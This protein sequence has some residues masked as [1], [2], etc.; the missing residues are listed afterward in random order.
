MLGRVHS[1]NVCLYDLRCNVVSYQGPTVKIFIGR[2]H[3]NG[4]SK[5]KSQYIDRASCERQ[6]TAKESERIIRSVWED[7][8]RQ[9]V[10]S[11]LQRMYADLNEG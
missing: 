6:R 5:D 1:P 8:E 10:R 4:T 7:I 3:V 11:A 9:R 2:S